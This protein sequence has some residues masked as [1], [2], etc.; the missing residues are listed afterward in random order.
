MIFYKT[1]RPFKAISFDLDDT[2]YDNEPVIRKAEQQF[3]VFLNNTY[4]KLAELDERRWNLYKALIVK[5]D[6]SLKHDVTASRK[7]AIQRVMI[8]HGIAPV[9]A[10]AWSETALQTF[11]ALRSE[12]DVPNESIELLQQL[13]KHY[14]VIAITN[15]N[16]DV[17]KIGLQDKFQ[18][19]LKAGNGIKSKPDIA[20]FQQAADQLDIQISD[21]LHVG[22]HLNSDVFGAQQH[23]AQAVWFN[24]K[25]SALK[26]AKLLPTIEIADLQA[27]LNLL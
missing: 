24:P 21:L 1:L 10:I 13:A 26:G 2:L 3:L 22:D 8:V 9:D 12:V 7:A 18:F 15:G 5:E 6:P 25:G 11:I 19:V 23:D 20:L 17:E 27:L 16:V 4:E 14:P